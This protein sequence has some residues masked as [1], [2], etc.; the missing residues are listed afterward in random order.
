MNSKTLFDRLVKHYKEN[1]EVIRQT[2]TRSAVNVAWEHWASV[3][4]PARPESKRS[5]TGIVDPEALVLLSLA[6]CK[7]ERRLEDMVRWWARVG[8]PL[9]SVQRMKSIAGQMDRSQSE[10]FSLFS[11]F[12]SEFGHRR[13][14][15]YASL[16]DQ[17]DG[18]IRPPGPDELSLGSP[19]SLILKLRAAFGIGAKPD[20]LAFLIGSAGGVS[21]VSFISQALGYT[22]TAVRD[23]LSD[24]VMAGIVQETSD[25]PALYKTN[26]QLWVDLLGIKGRNKREQPLWFMWLPLFGFLIAAHGIAYSAL[27]AASSE[28]TAASSARDI[29]EQYAYAFQHHDIPLP[30]PSDY[31][32][33]EYASAFLITVQSLS[34][35]MSTIS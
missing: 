5:R 32:G 19:C 25:R 27:D 2:I 10:N 18:I 1:W 4:S 35:W 22:K 11:K 12:A 21:S 28:Y 33:R 14:N 9:T 29:V 16:S 15:R 13:W 7:D 23:A 20:V 24:M 3:G 26:R 6:F 30:D 31:Q 17:R 34:R 8:S